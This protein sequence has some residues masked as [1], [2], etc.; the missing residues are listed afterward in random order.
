MKY[1]MIFFVSPKHEYPYRF[2][3][4]LVEPGPLPKDQ[5][6]ALR[7]IVNTWLAET[8]IEFK[9]ETGLL[10]ALKDEK[11]AMMFQLRFA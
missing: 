8:G 6:P 11:D 7:N 9:Y 5:I 4:D 3:F 2:R 10:W 1:P